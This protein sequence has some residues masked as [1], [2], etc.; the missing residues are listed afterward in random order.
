MER[1]KELLSNTELRIF[2]VAD[3][4]GFSSH[5]NFSKYF[6]SFFDLSPKDF[7]DH[8]LKTT[9]NSHE[10]S[11]N[12]IAVLPFVNFSDDK[13]QEYFSDGITEDIINVLANIPSLKVV[14]RTSSFSFKNK[15]VDLK[16]IGKSLGVNHILEG[17]VRRAGNK[18]RITAQLVKVSNGYNMWSQKYDC[19]SN[20]LF[21]IQDEISTSIITEIKDELLGGISHQIAKR[22]IRDPEAHE[23]YLKGLYF[24]NKYSNADNFRKAIDYFEKALGIDPNYTECLSEMASC[25]IQLWF[26]SQI[27]AKE[28]IE[29]AQSLIDKAYENENPPASLFVR[30][31]HLK[32]WYSWDLRGA[33]LLLEK[34]LRLAPNNVEAQL[35]LSVALTYLGD[36]DLAEEYIVKCITIDPLSA[37]LQ[38][39]HAWTLWYKGDLDRCEKILEKLIAF[40]PK[41]WGGHYLKGVVFLETHRS[42]K[43]LKFVEKA[44]E[45]Y[46]SSMT[47]AIVAQTHLL[48]GNFQE[49]QDI[50]TRIEMHSH[51]FPATNFDLG[52]LYMGLGQ[53]EKSR[54]YFQKALD[55]HEGRMLFLI[56]SCR[57]IS[58]IKKHP[59]FKPF[60][61]HMRSVT[62]PV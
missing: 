11:D 54:D 15:A 49:T 41:F 2:E 61:D 42:D 31:A 19:E 57:K 58:F 8:D 9:S 28:S 26:F 39:S 17:S 21:L 48:N 3:A 27:E 30:D 7:R 47:F 59:Y 32:I 44:A 35:H 33:R 45:L 40:K 6:K 5:Q 53:F 25:Y 20:D 43:A 1:A 14:G 18:L 46:P 38:F 13:E 23:Y 51:L 12:T 52:H 37:I 22:N 29:L 10:N 56:P 50:I 36:F 4:V 62:S 55:A 16:I 60:F 24:L 34:A